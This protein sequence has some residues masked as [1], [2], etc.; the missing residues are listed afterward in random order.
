MPRYLVATDFSTR[1]DRAIRRACL[2]A[3]EHG[4]ELVLTHVVDD[5]RPARLVELERGAAEAL[6][7]DLVRTLR[8]VDGLAAQARLELGEPFAGILAAA[9]AS[10][11]ALMVLGPHR[12]Q[13]LREVFVG[14]TVERVIR[15]SP[16]PVLMANAV[17]ASAYRRIVLATDLSAGSA[18]AAAALVALGLARSAELVALHAVATPATTTLLRTPLAAE[19]V[20]DYVAQERRRAAAGLAEF[21]AAAGIGRARRVVVAADRPVGAVLLEA[22]RRLRADLLVTGTRGRSG[23]SRLVLGSVAEAILRQAELDVLV[24][25]PEPGRAAEASGAGP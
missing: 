4:A 10:G 22:A 17:P 24:V 14:T 1:S 16:V 15:A 5:D 25:P 23:L 11:A 7:A 12:R 20:A 6:L 9:R 19:T 8:E 13:L 18:A 2:L 21:L 3:R